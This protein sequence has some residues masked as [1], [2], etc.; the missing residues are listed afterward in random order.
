MLLP[1]E[2]MLTA[3]EFGA[4]EEKEYPDIKS[5]L[6][7]QPILQQIDINKHPYLQT[8]FSKIAMAACLLQPGDSPE[9]IA[10]MK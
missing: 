4:N 3:K 1:Y 10:A 2:H 7:S 5:A 9:S 6:L 8:D